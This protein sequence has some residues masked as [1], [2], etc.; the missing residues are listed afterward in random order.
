MYEIGLKTGTDKISEHRYHETYP[1]YIERLYDLPGGMIEIGLEP[2]H[3]LASLNMWKELF[4]NMHIYGLDIT[5]PDEEGERYT[6]YQCDQSQAAD[7]DKCIQKIKPPIHFINDDG[8]HIPEHQILTFNKLFP[9]LEVGGVYII[10]DIE[11]SYWTEGNV[12]GYPT[13]YGKNHP[14]SIVEIFKR[15]VDGVNGTFSRSTKGKVKHQKQIASI[16]FA[17][18][19]IMI[20]KKERE[21]LGSY[22]F[23]DR[24]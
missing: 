14:M 6:I 5:T 20:S 23:A 2:K 10:E 22:R 16:S 11:T 15:A 19:C 4:P 8:S 7:L 18:N 12:Y 24:L 17:K 3:G 9:L 21:E 13:K 1:T